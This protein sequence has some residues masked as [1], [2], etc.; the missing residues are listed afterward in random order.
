VK[1]I[2][3]PE[4]SCVLLTKI[5][6]ASRMSNFT[7]TINVISQKNLFKIASRFPYLHNG[8]LRQILLRFQGFALYLLIPATFEEHMHDVTCT[9]AC[10]NRSLGDVHRPLSVS[11]MSKFRFCSRSE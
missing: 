5:M 9:M 3:S 7:F 8:I 2:R 10:V 11:T 4:Q 1:Q 6:L